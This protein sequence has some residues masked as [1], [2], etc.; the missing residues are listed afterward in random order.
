MNVI[1][2]LGEKGNELGTVNCT[3]EGKVLLASITTG[4]CVLCNRIGTTLYI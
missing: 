1:V 4:G 3:V 2:V